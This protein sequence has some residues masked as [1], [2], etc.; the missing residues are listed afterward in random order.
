VGVQGGVGSD[1]SQAAAYLDSGE[2]VRVTVGTFPPME[3]TV[4][5]MQANILRLRTDR[6]VLP[7]RLNSIRT[8][9]VRRNRRSKAVEGGILGGLVGGLLGRLTLIGVSGK[10][11]ESLGR[12]LAPGFGA[13]IGGLTGA[14]LGSRLA[15]DYWEVVPVPRPSVHPPPQRNSF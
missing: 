10:H 7:I 9:E 12:L 5:I 4:Q 13:I 1:T 3:G 6:R 14:I 11:W 2:E 8:L 15:G